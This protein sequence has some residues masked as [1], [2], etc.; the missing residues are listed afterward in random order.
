MLLCRAISGC[1]AY[2]CD[3]YFLFLVFYNGCCY[4]TC[5]FLQ[6]GLLSCCGSVVF[7]GALKRW[8]RD[9]GCRTNREQTQPET[10]MQ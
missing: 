4:L 9:N 5:L 1:G 7:G 10:G 3:V 6:S 2:L 8:Q